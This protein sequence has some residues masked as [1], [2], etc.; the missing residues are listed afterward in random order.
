MPFKA[1]K[2]KLSQIKVQSNIRYMNAFER[3]VF[4]VYTFFFA[5]P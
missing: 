4:L 3:Y 1:C 2:A 5:V